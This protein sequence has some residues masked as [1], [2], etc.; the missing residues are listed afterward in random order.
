[1]IKCSEKWLRKWIDPLVDTQGLTVGLTHL[2]LEVSTLELD[3]EFTHVIIGEIMEVSL[4]PHADRLKICLVKT[5]KGALLSVV[6]GAPNARVGIKVPIALP[7]AVLGTVTIKPTRIRGIDSLG[8]LCSAKELGLPQGANEGL[9]ELPEDAPL[10]QDLATYLDLPDIILDIETIPNRGD[11]LS[12]QGLAR[13][14]SALYHIPLNPLDVYHYPPLLLTKFVP[15]VTIESSKDCL[16]YSART[17]YVN[18]RLPTPLWLSERL[19]RSDIGSINLIVDIANYVMLELGQ[20]LHAFDCASLGPKLVVRHAKP[21]E[22]FMISPDNIR[23]LTEEVLVIADDKVL[24]IAGVIG[25]WAARI[26]PHTT[27]IFLESACFTPEAVRKNQAFSHT[28]EAGYRFAR[29]VDWQGTKRALNRATDLICRLANGLID[30]T[31]IWDNDLPPLM[32]IKLSTA[33]IKRLLGIDIKLETMQALLTH[34]HPSPVDSTTLLIT[35]PSYRQDLR[36]EAD[37]VEEVIRF[38]GYDKITPQIPEGALHFSGNT[39]MCDVIKHKITML[40]YKESLTY[41][42]ID[43]DFYALFDYPYI[44]LLNPLSKELGGLRSVIWPSLVQ[45]LQYNY[46]RQQSTNQIFEIGSCFAPPEAETKPLESTHVGLAWIGNIA[47]LQWGVKERLTSFYDLKGHVT[48]IL[49]LLGYKITYGPYQHPSLHPFLT[50]GLYHEE[51]LIGYIGALHPVLQ[52]K[53]EFKTPVWI[54][55]ITCNTIPIIVQGKGELPSKYPFIRRDLSLLIPR[56]QDITTINETLYTIGGAWLKQ[57][58]LFDVYVHEA[59]E[60]KKSL[61]FALIFQ[62][63]DSTLTDEKVNE[64]INIMLLK[65]HELGYAELRT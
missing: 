46:Y 56:D 41:S 5:G 15:H 3:V 34:L 38:Y 16:Y 7:G 13:E 21:C 14:L 36:I 62:D 51:V 61:A 24:A 42:F 27:K 1:M 6:C 23:T 58:T 9:L 48:I 60:G 54:A 49:N 37:L 20:P 12:I 17:F 35:P 4:H 30:D 32:P 55:E 53:L 47:P 65:L 45:V 44:P 40:G 2:G 33:T 22:A 8:M 28:T 39:S 19:R 50:Q 10:G 52:K 64:Q 57:A 43:P 31:W 11:T 29:G 26:T 59:L 18:N 25:G 63:N